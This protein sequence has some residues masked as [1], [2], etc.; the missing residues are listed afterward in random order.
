MGIRRKSNACDYLTGKASHLGTRSDSPG[1]AE[2]ASGGCVR[3][4]C[5]RMC[6]IHQMVRTPELV[7]VTEA[8]SCFIVGKTPRLGARITQNPDYEK[9]S[10]GQVLRGHVMSA[11]RSTSVFCPVGRA[12]RNRITS[13]SFS[14]FVPSN[15]RLFSTR[16]VSV[17]VWSSRRLSP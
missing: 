16:T 15:F 7:L 9:R 6:F 17:S 14:K 8:R 4:A 11:G 5:R 10:S 1:N 2:Q 13:E 12:P 3:F